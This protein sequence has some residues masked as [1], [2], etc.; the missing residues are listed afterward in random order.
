MDEI[1]NIVT[2][3]LKNNNMKIEIANGNLYLKDFFLFKIV[4]R[5]SENKLVTLFYSW[6]I[7]II[8]KL[9]FGAKY[10]KM[11]NIITELKNE[12]ENRDYKV[13]QIVKMYK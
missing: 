1:L 2:S 4:I 8:G 7:G 5:K 10:N 9:M 13:I 12:F 6:N 3:S 11:M